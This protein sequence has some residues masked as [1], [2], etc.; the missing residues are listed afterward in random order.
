[1]IPE[2]TDT[3]ERRAVS[4]FDAH[5]WDNAIVPY[6]FDTKADRILCKDFAFP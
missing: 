4:T 6:D 3:R 2:P 5:K 1:M